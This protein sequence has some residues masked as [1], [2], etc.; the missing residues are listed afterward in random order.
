M[1]LLKKYEITKIEGFLQSKLKRSVYHSSFN[2]LL[3]TV[4]VNSDPQLYIHGLIVQLETCMKVIHIWPEGGF[5]SW[6]LKHVLNRGY[7]I[8]S[9]ITFCKWIQIYIR[10]FI[11]IPVISSGPYDVRHIGLWCSLRTRSLLR[12]HARRL[13]WVSLVCAQPGLSAGVPRSTQLRSHFALRNLD[14]NFLLKTTQVWIYI[15][16]YIYQITMLLNVLWPISLPSV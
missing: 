11:Q 12:N 16:H 6:K 8:Y 2:Y 4:F 10:F 14:F 3:F 7:D 13:S 5:H 15:F 9:F 1:P